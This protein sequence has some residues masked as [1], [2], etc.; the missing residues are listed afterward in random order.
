MQFKHL[1][2][3]CFFALSC[4]FIEP[5]LAQ[6]K[7]ITGKVTDKKDGSPLIGVSVGAG[8]GSG[9]LTSADGTFRLSV[10]ANTAGLTFS[11]LGYNKLTS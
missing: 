11:Y 3:L 7:V 9:T 4:L 6:N 8:A 10:P 1:L 5:A 2:A